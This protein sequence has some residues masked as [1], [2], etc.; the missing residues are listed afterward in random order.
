MLNN[1]GE[2]ADA[3][4]QI[5]MAEVARS[6][7]LFAQTVAM[8]P[9]PPTFNRAS[10]CANGWG[11]FCALSMVSGYNTSLKIFGPDGAREWLA[12]TAQYLSQFAQNEGHN[13][14]IN[15]TVKE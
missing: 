7:L 1:E 13:I 15:L 3:L 8:L 14:T 11:Y 5:A 10:A 6:N 4:F 2:I 9:L 12:E